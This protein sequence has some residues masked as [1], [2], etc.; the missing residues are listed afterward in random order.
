MH[1]LKKRPTY[2]SKQHISVATK[3]NEM[4][5]SA[6]KAICHH[7]YQQRFN[8]TVAALQMKIDHLSTPKLAFKC[9]L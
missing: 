9:F 1:F 4:L 7:I 3:Q 6:A 8:A 2:N 5:G